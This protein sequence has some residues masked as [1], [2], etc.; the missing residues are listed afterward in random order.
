MQRKIYTKIIAS[1]I[2]SFLFAGSPAMAQQKVSKVLL[3]GFWWDY[4]NN[5]FR[6][7]WANYLTELAPRLRAMGIDA[8]WIPP[9]AKNNSAGSVG[10]APFDMYD[11]GDKYQKQQG[12]TTRLGTK[13]ELLRMIAVMH[14]NGIEVIEDMVINHNSDAAGAGGQDTEPGRSMQSASGYKNF[15]FVSYKTP[16]I[17]ESVNDYWT[18][19]TITFIPTM[20]T[21]AM[22]V[23]YAVLFG[24]RIL[25]MLHRLLL[26]KVLTYPHPARL[27]LLA[28]QDL[29]T[30]RHNP[31]ITC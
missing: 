19:S 13:D 12:D 21:T 31:A 28:L 15:R 10:Y 9:A 14:A 25:I 4:W 11:L 20:P 26:G 24:D 18:R 30:I 3:Q 1:F 2:A 7:G 22:Q 27:P 8:I 6:F 29:I 17:D 5:N 16:R 23:I